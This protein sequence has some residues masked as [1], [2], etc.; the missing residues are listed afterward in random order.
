MRNSLK[1]SSGGKII[2]ARREEITE[3]IAEG[4]VVDKEVPSIL[5][6]PRA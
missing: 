4:N 5:D 3:A 2:P 6:K 1:D